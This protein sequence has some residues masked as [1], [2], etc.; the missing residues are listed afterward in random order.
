MLNNCASPVKRPAD[1]ARALKK[2]NIMD[3]PYTKE[4][5]IEAVK[6]LVKYFSDGKKDKDFFGLDDLGIINIYLSWPN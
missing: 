2:E 6:N 3:C 5:A 1:R 4:D